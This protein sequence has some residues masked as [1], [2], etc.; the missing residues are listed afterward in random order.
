[1]RGLH[2]F[3]A[4]RRRRNVDDKAY[5]VHRKIFT[6]QNRELC[7]WIVRKDHLEIHHFCATRTTL[8]GTHVPLIA[9]LPK[10]TLLIF[11]YNS[12]VQTF[13]SSVPAFGHLI[14]SSLPAARFTN[15][16]FLGLA[17][18]RL[19]SIIPLWISLKSLENLTNLAPHAQLRNH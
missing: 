13:P 5:R 14:K 10:S 16:L 6:K 12:C 3:S 11:K 4:R 8:I 15:K 19:F 7:L 17:A 2:L 18:P 9:S 1:M